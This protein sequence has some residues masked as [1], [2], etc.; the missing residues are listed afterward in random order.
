MKVEIFTTVGN[1]EYIVPLFL[2]HYRSAFPDAVI[3]VA[4][5][6]ST[7][8]SVKLCEE[9]GCKISFFHG[10]V[11]YKKEPILTH[12]KNSCWKKS[13]A[14]WIIVCDIDEL[15]HISQKDLVDLDD[16]DIIRFNGYNMFDEED[17]QDPE[18]MVWGAPSS[19]YSKCC[20]FRKRIGEIRYQH[21]AHLCK[22]AK[23]FRVLENKYKL[24]HYKKGCFNFENYCALNPTVKRSAH[25][26]IW[27]YTRKGLTKVL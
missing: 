16:V 10:Y 7:D 4:A 9:A 19:P 25:E 11:P 6:N 20:M 1:M 27:N 3:N 15:C 13:D 14:D 22:P 23:N 26:L 24:L 21:G 18:L 17:V 5:C 12:L 2:K 8:N